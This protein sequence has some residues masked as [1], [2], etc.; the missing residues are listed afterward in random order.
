MSV[1]VSESEELKNHHWAL[2]ELPTFPAIATKLLKTLNDDSA[3][4]KTMVELLRSDAAF[5]AEILRRANSASMGLR[6]QVSSLQHAIML[7]GFEQ[8]RQLAMAVSMSTYLKPSMKMASLKKCWTHSLA[9]ANL[10]DRVARKLQF[11]HDRAYTAG[12]LHHIGLFGLMVHYPVE[13]DGF[14]ATS[15]E[16]SLREWEAENF[17]LDHCE[18]GDS[19]S[20]MWDF[21]PEIRHAA[22]H[23]EDSPEAGQL[24]LTTI[25]HWCSHC[26]VSIGHTLG[27]QPEPYADLRA[28][29]PER[30]QK[31][32]PEDMA[33]LAAD[34]KKKVE[35]FG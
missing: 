4:I 1:A 26:A 7:L 8:M 25:I 6:S 16:Q 33:E 31:A 3:D 22:A 27:K 11:E 29:M 30:I 5:S 20:E 21:P 2:R 10:A 14:F 18:A 34:I 13:Y 19:L 17:G 15:P 28:R 23:H 12:L 35:S 24:D 32:L 9:T